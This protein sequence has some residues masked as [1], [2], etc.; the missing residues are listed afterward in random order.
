MEQFIYSS[1]GVVLIIIWMILN[2]KNMNKHIQ[3]VFED[4]STKEEIKSD[5]SLRNFYYYCEK[6]KIDCDLRDKEM[7]VNYNGKKILCKQDGDFRMGRTTLSV[8][9]K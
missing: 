2:K 6:R 4:V 1:V 7:I 9:K 3:S 8:K 5:A